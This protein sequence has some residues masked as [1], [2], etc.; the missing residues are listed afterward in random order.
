MGLFGATLRREFRNIGVQSGDGGR[1]H[2]THLYSLLQ[3]QKHLHRNWSLCSCSKPR[4]AT[5]NLSLLPF[6]PCL[7][8][9]SHNHCP[10][11]PSLFPNLHCIQP[12]IT[13]HVTFQQKPYNQKEELPPIKWHE[14]CSVTK[15]WG[16]Y[17][18]L[19]PDTHIY[20]GS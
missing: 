8:F 9:L 3:P 1:V 10:L 20:Q 14:D 12:K 16:K 11:L 6:F 18:F 7:V 19:S 13:V 15:S 5:P 2:S 17:N 4:S